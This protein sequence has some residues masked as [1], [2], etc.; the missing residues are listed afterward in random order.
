MEPF[1]HDTPSLNASSL[2]RIERMR[3]RPDSLAKRPRS[4]F[5][6]I[7]SAVLLAFTLGLVA[8]PWFESQIRRQLPAFAGS[9]TPTADE[10]LAQ[11][12]ELKQLHQRLAALEAKP[13]VR[14]APADP[15]G[16]GQLN[17]RLGSANGRIDALG[18]QVNQL[19]AKVDAT[20]TATEATLASAA[21]DAEAAQGVLLLS[22]TRRA[23]ERG[24]LLA[25]VVPGAEAGLQRL[26]GNRYASSVAAIVAL[27][28]APVTSRSLARELLALQPV[29]TNSGSDAEISW[30]DSVTAGL[31]SI[32]RIRDTSVAPTDPADRLIVAQRALA[33]GKIDAAAA[34]IA[35]LPVEKRRLAASWLAN[36]ARLRNGMRGLAVLEGEAIALT[37]HAP[38]G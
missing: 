24:D 14:A 9:A 32:V 23:L 2:E 1:D 4:L 12:K 22:L 15:G 13:V 16:V 10:I 36:A 18:S 8:N 17:S 35:A 34:Q 28:T 3:A 33:M 31:S 38:E 26:F 6:W 37:M 25:L 21:Q 27:G 20:A 7:M 5:P 29:L 11:S 30:W 19:A